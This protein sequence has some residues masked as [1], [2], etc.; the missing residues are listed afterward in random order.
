VEYGFCGPDLL[1]LMWLVQACPKMLYLRCKALITIH[2]ITT[3]K[4]M[5]L[6]NQIKRSF[7]GHILYFTILLYA[8]S[9][10]LLMF[11]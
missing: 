6:F 11:K 1:K 2:L 8:V 5:A 7:S 4:T 3:T 10:L 9:M